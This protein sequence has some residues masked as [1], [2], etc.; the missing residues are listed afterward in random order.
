V[1]RHILNILQKAKYLFRIDT[2]TYIDAGK[3]VTFKEAA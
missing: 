2:T 1:T 3:P